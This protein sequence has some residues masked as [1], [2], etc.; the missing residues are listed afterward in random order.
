MKYT[1]FLYLLFLF[2]ISLFSYGRDI[3]SILQYHLIFGLI[4][5][6]KLEISILTLFTSV[7]TSQWNF[8]NKLSKYTRYNSYC[9]SMLSVRLHA[10]TQVFTGVSNNKLF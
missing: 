9:I 6:K 1:L 10:Y 4:V 8:I 5:L 7:H 2:A 3:I